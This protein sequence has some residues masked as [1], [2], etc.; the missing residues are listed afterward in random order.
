MN[1]IRTITASLRTVGDAV[2][3]E[4][5]DASSARFRRDVVAPLVAASLALARAEDLAR[6]EIDRARRDL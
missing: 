2:H 5:N 4:W 1:D 6:A 3:E